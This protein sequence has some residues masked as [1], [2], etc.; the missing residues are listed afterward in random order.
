MAFHFFSIPTSHGEAARDELNA[1][2][3]L[4]HIGH[5]KSQFVA[6]GTAS[7]WA[8]CI[9]VVH[10]ADT[11]PDSLRPNRNTSRAIGGE[12]PKIDYKTALS[13]GEFGLFAELREVRKELAFKA[14]LPTYAVF[15]NEQL[16][17]LAKVRPT[18]PQAMSAI[19]SIGKSKNDEFAKVFL[20]AIAR[21][22][23][24]EQARGTSADSPA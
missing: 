16:A 24:H 15:N 7:F 18:S 22:L 4:G 8:F 2:L 9:E 10:N 5:V 14:G 12:K 11:L 19:A 3:A 20:V 13:S 21:N 17:D 23:A 6:D 1:L